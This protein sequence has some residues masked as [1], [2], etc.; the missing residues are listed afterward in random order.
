ML[1]LWGCGSGGSGD[2]DL[3]VTD[4]N[5]TSGNWTDGQTI[6]GTVSLQNAGGT[7]SSASHV[8]I[9]LSTNSQISTFDILLADVSVPAL[10]AG[11][12]QTVDVSLVFDGTALI[13]P[14]SHTLYYGAIADHREVV[15]E[16]NENNND[17]HANNATGNVTVSIDSG[18]L[19]ISSI[20]ASSTVFQDNTTVKIDYVLTNTGTGTVSDSHTG[21]YLSSNTT[22][23]TSDHLIATVAETALQAGT[24]RAGSLLIDIDLSQSTFPAVGTYYLGAIGNYQNIADETTDTNNSAYSSSSISLSAAPGT[25]PDLTVTSL[26]SADL[27]WDTGENISVSANLSNSGT[28]ATGAG[29]RV[30]LYLSTDP[31]FNSD[32]TLIGTY[33]ASALAVG[34][35]VSPSFSV[36]VSSLSL[37]AGVYALGIMPDTLGAIAET[38]ETN[39]SS[40]VD[41]SDS[42][43]PDLVTITL[44]GGAKPT[45]VTHVDATYTGKWGWRGTGSN[46]G[47]DGPRGTGVHAWGTPVTETSTTES[48]AMDGGSLSNDPINEVGAEYAYSLGLDGSGVLV[49]VIDSH[50]NGAHSDLDGNYIG[51]YNASTQEASTL[52]YDDHGTHVA[53][54]IAGEKDGSGMHGAAYGANIFGVSFGVTSDD[55][56]DVSHERLANG[57]RVATDKG[58][59]I[60]NNSWGGEGDTIDERSVRSAMADAIDQGAVFVW[61][62]GNSYSG[63]TTSAEAQKALVYAEL[64]GGFVNVVNLRWDTTTSQWEIANATTGDSWPSS[65]VCGV[66]MDY[67]LG[68]PGTDINSAVAN[69]DYD[70][71]S[72]TSMAAPMVSGGL[73]ILFQAFPY[74]ETADILQLMFVTA[75]DLGDA[76]VDEIYGHG[77]MNLEAALQPSGSMNIATTRSTASNVGIAAAQT[78]LQAES[79]LAKAISEAASD[80]VVLD[81]F[82]RAFTLGAVGISAIEDLALDE[83]AAF[84]QSLQADFEGLAR[85]GPPMTETAAMAGALAVL[86][87][88]IPLGE[89][90]LRY[91]AITKEGAASAEMQYMTLKQGEAWQTNRSVTLI[92]EEGQLF[93]N[94]GTGAYAL[95]DRATTLSLATNGR[96]Q[97]GDDWTL[98][99]G[100]GL[101]QTAIQESGSSLIK[102]SD[103]LTSASAI[104]GIRRDG[105][106]RHGAGQL[107]MQLGQD[108]LVLGGT[109]E[110]RVPV[111]RE[112]DGVILFEETQL[113][114]EDLSLRPQFEISYTDQMTGEASYALSTLVNEDETRIAADWQR[115]F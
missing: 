21:I 36:D 83:A 33:D 112:A 40:Y 102:V 54:I 46:V 105:M 64:A 28:Q 74:V 34:A 62:A 51:Y 2:P 63:T 109:M 93:G 52:T 115:S 65:Q 113:A 27:D 5:L 91:R 16:A 17:D 67:C 15:L 90:T 24:S 99:G 13:G 29:F 108:R 43:A 18:D 76:G 37:A 4:L 100:L 101:N 32:D 44:N 12:S 20:S 31:V 104:L 6:T 56:L 107:A 47:A 106:G 103:E 111:G 41:P 45:S 48:R 39:N 11:Q 38:N 80:L 92:E 53:G 88:Q 86:G 77:M 87:D 72:G 30:G 79:P 98:F 25:G 61:A 19:E 9:F 35:S 84:S 50:I 49:T 7:A 71:I 78:S 3:V 89:G 23:S 42:A 26:S 85:F 55:Y 96:R 70:I 22:I 95:A 94:R 82:D 14:G 59:R 68:A 97:I 81:A 75:D 114:A 10:N 69:G 66:T 1:L 8:G 58:A 60:F 73:A 110:I 57:I